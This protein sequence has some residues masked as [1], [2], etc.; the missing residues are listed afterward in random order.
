MKST[1][2]VLWLC[3]LLI[4]SSGG[5][6]AYDLFFDLCTRS[7]AYLF[8]VSAFGE[9]GKGVSVYGFSNMEGLRYC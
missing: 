2:V 5:L 6:F 7:F 3:L 4:I 9:L 8:T 1:P